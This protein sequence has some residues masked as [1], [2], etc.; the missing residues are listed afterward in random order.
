MSKKIHVIKINVIPDEKKEK[1]FPSLFFMLGR[2]GR[3][4]TDVNDVLLFL[5]RRGVDIKIV[6]ELRQR[7]EICQKSFDKRIENNKKK[8]EELLDDD[9]KDEK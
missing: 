1:P 9:E 7:A 2:F 8:M 6:E 3:L 5:I 4:F